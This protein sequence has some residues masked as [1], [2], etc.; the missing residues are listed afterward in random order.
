MEN[1][2]NKKKKNTNIHPK[3]DIHFI[4]MFSYWTPMYIHLFHYYLEW[5]ESQCILEL[6]KGSL[7][8]V[9]RIAQQQMEDERQR[10]KNAVV[11][12]NKFNSPVAFF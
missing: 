6:F 5:A 9:H 1:E 12:I 8:D 2:I 4:S 7:I 11:T 3:R 10:G